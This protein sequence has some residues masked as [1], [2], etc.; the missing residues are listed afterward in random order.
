MTEALREAIEKLTALPEE[1][2]KRCAARIL[3]FLGEGG[4]AAA[5]EGKERFWLNGSRSS[6][7]DV[8]KAVSELKELRNDQT[9][10]GLGIREM[11]EEGR[12]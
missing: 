10:G 7:D 8:A 5:R 1:E 9:F 4:K 3:E 6:K 2:Q 12:L 11:I